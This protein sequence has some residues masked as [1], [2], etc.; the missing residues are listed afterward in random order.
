ME[1][2]RERV[3]EERRELKEKFDKLT[4]FIYG[5]KMEDLPFEERR[6]L[7]VQQYIMAQYLC[8]LDERIDDFP[9]EG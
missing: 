6:R 1:A 3:L 9:Q 4:I 5:S 7:I 2:F 8:V